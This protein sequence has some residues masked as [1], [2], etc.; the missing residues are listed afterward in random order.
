MFAYIDMSYSTD[1]F[2]ISYIDGDQKLK[3][4]MRNLVHFSE[5]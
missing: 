3:R 2:P 5:V 4:I 1:S